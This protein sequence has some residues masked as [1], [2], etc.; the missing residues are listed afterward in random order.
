[1]ADSQA[2]TPVGVLSYACND[3]FTNS[4]QNFKKIMLPRQRLDG[5]RTLLRKGGFKNKDIRLKENI[6]L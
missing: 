5:I 2:E 3:H 6:L 4:L 1:M